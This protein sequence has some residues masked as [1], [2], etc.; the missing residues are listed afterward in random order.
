MPI[1]F[2]I[3]NSLMIVKRKEKIM[4]ILFVMLIM[5]VALVTVAIAD[6]AQLA[7]AIAAHNAQCA[8]VQAGT[9]LATVCAQEA[10][11]LQARIAAS[12]K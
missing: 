2:K 3:N 4:K 6:D 11:A 9:P 5:F 8:N 12:K 7:A 1:H 10:A